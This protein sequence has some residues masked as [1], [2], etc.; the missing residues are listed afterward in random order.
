MIAC[1]SFGFKAALLVNMGTEGYQERLNGVETST[2]LGKFNMWT[3]QADP[4]S[5]FVADFI[6]QLR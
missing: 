1:V 5:L 2:T 3:L 4:I 6:N